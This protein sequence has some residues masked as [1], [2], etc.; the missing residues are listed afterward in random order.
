M[1][2]Y[3]DNQ[4][5]LDLND[6]GH[7]SFWSNRTHGLADDADL[8]WRDVV[9]QSPEEVFGNEQKVV[10]V[11]SFLA[12]TSD[13]PTEWRMVVVGEASDPLSFV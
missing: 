2:G 3:I 10:Y 12:I 7:L 13:E 9:G 5:P 8:L 1:I 4:P 11:A 6:S